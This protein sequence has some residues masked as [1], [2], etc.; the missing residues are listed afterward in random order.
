MPSA[1]RH[2]RGIEALI[3]SIG[4]LGFVRRKEEF[5]DTLAAILEAMELKH[6]L[7]ALGEECRNIVLSNFPHELLAK[8][9]VDRNPLVAAAMKSPTGIVWSDT[10]GAQLRQSD[11]HYLAK[12]R[13]LNLVSG[14]STSVVRSAECR[15]TVIF[16]GDRPTRSPSLREYAV[17]ASPHI[18]DAASRVV[19]SSELEPGGTL[20]MRQ[21]ECLKLVARGKSDWEAGRLLGIKQS[22]VHAH[23]E[24][25]R[26]RF[27]VRRR[28]QLIAKALHLGIIDIS[29]VV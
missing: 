7:I 19:L 13:V 14:V 6:Y 17:A 15:G 4:R 1:I 27:G 22:T 23:I 2:T 9:P 26:E 21:M 28:T 3:S 29:D 11:R 8:S 12:M 10:D 18:L 16:A 25:V 24:A 20:T 5:H